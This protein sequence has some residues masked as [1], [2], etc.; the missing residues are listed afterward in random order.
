M[1][2]HIGF[3]VRNLKQSREFYEKALLPLAIKVLMEVTPEMT[4]GDSL[5]CGFGSHNK[6]SFWISSA[7]EIC[8]SIHIAFTASSRTEVDA[9]YHVALTAG[10]KDNGAPGLRTIYHPNY[11]GAFIIDMDGHNI[12]AVCHSAKSTA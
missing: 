9:F 7:G 6:P 11:Y 2:D 4:G 5:H 10:G 3:S 1:L 12:E 8:P